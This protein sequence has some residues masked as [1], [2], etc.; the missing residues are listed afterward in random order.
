[1]NLR[2]YLTVSLSRFLLCIGTE[3]LMYFSVFSRIQFIS[4][5]NSFARSFI[6][7]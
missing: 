2:L 7:R 3:K 1:M 6:N 5:L 4:G